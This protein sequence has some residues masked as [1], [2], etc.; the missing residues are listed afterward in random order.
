MSHAH[1]SN[2]NET[3]ASASTAMSASIPDALDALKRRLADIAN[4]EQA[5]SILSWDQETQMPSGAAGARAEQLTTLAKLIHR[6]ITDAGLSE[7][8][9]ASK[10]QLVTSGSSEHTL[11]DDEALLDVTDRLISHTQ[12][13][14]DTFVETWTRAVNVSHHAW[15]DARKNNDFAAFAPHLETMVDLSRRR[16]DYLG[17]D[18][19]P[20]D[21]LHDLY[22][23]DS[24]T[25]V[26][27]NVFAQLR[28][29]TKV[30]L[31]NIV[32]SATT[33]SADV[34]H[35][36][37]AEDSQKAFALDMATRFGYDLNRGRLDQAVHPFATSFSS[38]DV[39]I[40]TRYDPNFLGSALFGVLHESGHAMYEQGIADSLQRTPLASGA[41]LG[42][43]ESQSRLWENLVGRSKAFWEG[44]YS[45]LQETFPKQL[46][47]VS[48]EDFY[49]AINVV[50]PSLIRVEADEVTYNLHIMVRFELELELIE[51]TLAAKDLPEAWN[52]KYQDYLGI[53]PPDD[54]RGC[55]QDIH[56]SAGSFGYF[57]TYSLGNLMS[58]QL[59][60]A[61]K[62][63]H[64][65]IEDDIRHLRFDRLLTWLR[66][67]VHAHGSKYPP[68]V[69]LERA[70]GERLDAAPYV[71]YL[72]QKY[73]NLYGFTPQG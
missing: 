13:L 45:L 65:E 30:L 3:A 57:P 27:K 37:F 69:L 21:A 18:D 25:A 60:E 63:A 28:D 1:G 16:A 64:P 73:A 53:T 72:N 42:I 19:H 40:T 44:A 61:A 35:Q 68:Q 34:L 48:L 70:T 31:G 29:D 12:K 67:N 54:T 43:H 52:A 36:P 47:D 4:L 33:A 58:V 7:L 8:L 22:E 9:S 32:S 10:R 51:G 56:W 15:I 46:A 38:S 41:S 20:Y 71:R 5:A 26:L 55:L 49:H 11:S 62:T 24:S 23:R 14:P 2:A 39:R 50:S 66:D 59:F 6:H 17:Y